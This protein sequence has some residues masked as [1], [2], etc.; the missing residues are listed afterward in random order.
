MS[1]E[2]H[3]KN[4]HYLQSET[5]VAK[6]WCRFFITCTPNCEKATGQGKTSLDPKLHELQEKKKKFKSLWAL[7]P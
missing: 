1:H 7:K 3:K 5:K 4:P 2:V 6:Q